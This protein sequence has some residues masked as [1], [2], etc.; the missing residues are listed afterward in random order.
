[1]AAV[2]YSAQCDLPSGGTILAMPAMEP[3]SCILAMYARG[4]VNSAGVGWNT[5][6]SGRSSTALACSSSDLRMACTHDGKGRDS[7][8][9]LMSLCGAF[10]ACANVLNAVLTCTR[11][12][13]VELLEGTEGALEVAVQ[14]Q[15]RLEKFSRA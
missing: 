5:G 1:M 10:C 11:H 2:E 3:R 13:A 4:S 6:A 8:H 14:G 9:V 15:K 12:E 7:V